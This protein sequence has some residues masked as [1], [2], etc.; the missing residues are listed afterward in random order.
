MEKICIRCNITE[1]QELEQL[2]F[3]MLRDENLTF[4][5]EKTNLLF[6]VICELRRFYNKDN[7]E[8]YISLNKELAK[9]L[10]VNLKEEIKKANNEV[11]FD[12]LIRLYYK[13]LEKE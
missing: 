3:D 1:I 8:T 5:S 6:D 9:L 11:N 4:N 7:D 10:L 13:L 2:I 12:E